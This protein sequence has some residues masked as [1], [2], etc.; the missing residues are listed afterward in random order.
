VLGVARTVPHPG[1]ASE[2]VDDVRCV[3]Q[4][5]GITDD[6]NFGKWILSGFVSLQAVPAVT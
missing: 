6:E 3:A 1:L 2:H 4:R 5:N